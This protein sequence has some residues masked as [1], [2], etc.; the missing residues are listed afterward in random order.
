[1]IIII[2]NFKSA[3]NIFAN[4]ILLSCLI[5]LTYYDLSPA[6]IVLFNVAVKIRSTKIKTISP[7]YEYF[8]A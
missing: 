3:E 7:S 6:L 8:R 5:A 1:M 4:K 2:K